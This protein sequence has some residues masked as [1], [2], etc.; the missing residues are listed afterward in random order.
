M[1]YDHDA[2][3]KVALAIN[4]PNQV[5]AE[6][7]NLAN[8]YIE[9]ADKH[10][11]LKLFVAET[12][13]ILTKEIYDDVGNREGLAIDCKHVAEE[14]VGLEYLKTKWQM[15]RAIAAE[16]KVETLVSALERLQYSYNLILAR[17]PVR[18]VSETLAEVEHALKAA[19]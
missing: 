13:E 4:A 1:K 11:Q 6:Y 14:K 15:D 18:D 3:L 2:A 19:K 10:H 7:V 8:A 16:K 17:K 5:A 9:L 12:G